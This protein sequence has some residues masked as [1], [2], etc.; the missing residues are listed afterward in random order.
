V[1]GAWTQYRGIKEGRRE[2]RRAE[3]INL[4]ESR[5]DD[6]LR[7]QERREELALQ[8]RFRSQDVG[9]RERQFTEEKRAQGVSEAQ[10]AEEFEFSK[11]VTQERLGMEERQVSLQERGFENDL[12]MQ[13]Y[14]K[15]QNWINNMLTQLNNNPGLSNNLIQI[16]RGRA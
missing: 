7:R 1:L 14:N 11:G 13:K 6:R 2:S 15:K 5:R 9:F 8:T 16:S 10:R 3:R 4:R 12:E